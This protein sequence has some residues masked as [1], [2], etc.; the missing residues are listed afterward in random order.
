M[1]V[2]LMVIGSGAV[3]A[4][5]KGAGALLGARSVPLMERLQ[6]GLAASMLAAL[7]VTQLPADDPTI[8]ATRAVGVA[9]A[10]TLIVLR[11]SALLAMAAAAVVAA[12]LRAFLG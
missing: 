2:W 1:T 7:I 9:T 4:L 6:P 5:M 3:S 12:G 8:A 11:A 10:G